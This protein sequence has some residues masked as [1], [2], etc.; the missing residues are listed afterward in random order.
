MNLRGGLR[1]LPLPKGEKPFHH[2]G[3]DRTGGRAFGART[4][5]T[6]KTQRTLREGRRGF[7]V[8]LAGVAALPWFACGAGRFLSL[9][10]VLEVVD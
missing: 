2:R 10:N 7:G 9:V 5:S 3:A 8:V 6:A 1:S 4:K